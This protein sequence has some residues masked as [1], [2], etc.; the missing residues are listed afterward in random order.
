MVYLKVLEAELRCVQKKN[1]F[2]LLIGNTEVW[3]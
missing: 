3:D 2:G 1:N